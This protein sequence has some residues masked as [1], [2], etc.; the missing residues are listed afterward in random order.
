MQPYYGKTPAGWVAPRRECRCSAGGS[1]RRLRGGVGSAGRGRGRPSDEGLLELGVLLKRDLDRLGDHVRPVRAAAEVLRV[2][3]LSS[4][5]LGGKPQGHGLELDHDLG[6]NAMSFHGP[7]SQSL[8]LG[9]L[10]RGKGYAAAVA[11]TVPGTS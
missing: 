1:A 8:L 7:P 3:L 6:L 9:C 11:G 10:G 4:D 2:L 5:E